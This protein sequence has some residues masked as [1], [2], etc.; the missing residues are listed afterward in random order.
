MIPEIATLQKK[1]SSDNRDRLFATNSAR[2][3]FTSSSKS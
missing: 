2:I 3:Y 1:D